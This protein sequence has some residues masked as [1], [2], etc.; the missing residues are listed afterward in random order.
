MNKKWVKTGLTARRHAAILQ[1]SVREEETA[2]TIPP[3]IDQTI[4][5]GAEMRLSAAVEDV[6]SNVRVRARS[7]PAALVSL[8]TERVCTKVLPTFI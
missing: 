8:V 2:E 4:W 6:S 3:S 5:E 1:T 7:C